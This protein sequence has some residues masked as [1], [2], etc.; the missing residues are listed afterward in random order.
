LLWLRA[1][2]AL[3]LAFPN[4]NH[5]TGSPS[6]SDVRRFALVTGASSKIGAACAEYF[7]SCGYDLILAAPR[8]V[9]I[10]TIARR[11]QKTEGR[12]VDTYAVG[13]SSSAG[14]SAIAQL[15]GERDDIDVFV[16]NT[17]LG[18]PKG[19]ASIN[20]DATENLTSISMLACT[21]LS[22][23]ALAG[24]RRRGHGTLVNIAACVS[25]NAPTAVA[26]ENASNAYV[27]AFS[28]ALQLEYANSGIVVK[29][30]SSRS[31]CTEFCEA[32]EGNS[33][34][35]PEILFRS[36]DETVGNRML[37]VQRKQAD[38]LLREGALP[39]QV[40]AVVRNFGLS[41]GPFAMR[42]LIGIDTSWRSRSGNDEVSR[43]EESLC[44]AGRLGL[45]VGRGYYLYEPDSWSPLPDSEVEKLILETCDRLDIKR[46][47]ITDDEILDRILYPMINEGARILEEGFVTCAEDI[48]A[49]W[50]QGYGWPVSWSGPMHY[51]DDIDL[52]IVFER[53]SYMAA[54]DSDASLRPAALLRKLALSGR[55]FSSHLVAN[56]PELA[57]SSS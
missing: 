22:H 54:T 8:E 5:P 25:S 3:L 16:N 44:E 23:A 41:I 55:T 37:A 47:T 56:P 32:S 38:K 35:C 7:A 34:L 12:Q 6:M 45:T 42:D 18:E 36:A 19:M 21:Q 30:V 9:Q 57:A 15:L 33:R 27:E 51:A 29:T 17:C 4:V 52:A 24:F 53:L 10:D 14:L 28:S 2:I 20:A 39:Q 1:V 48:D 40:D 31:L 50:R 13:L 11:I 46:R 49:I 26:G 43:I